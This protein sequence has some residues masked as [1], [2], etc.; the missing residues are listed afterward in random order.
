MMKVVYLRVDSL[1]LELP[2]IVKMEGIAQSFNQGEKYR[3]C[4]VDLLTCMV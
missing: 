3:V 1:P 4:G 2:V